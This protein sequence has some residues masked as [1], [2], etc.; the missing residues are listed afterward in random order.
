MRPSCNFLKNCKVPLTNLDLA[1]TLFQAGKKWLKGKIL[2]FNKTRIDFLRME[3]F[4]KT[5][6][7]YS[8]IHTYACA[9]QKERNT[10]FSDN[11]AKILDE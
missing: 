3:I 7:S 8:M 6:I 4:F 1:F 5:N 9:Y 10:N 11:F 2:F